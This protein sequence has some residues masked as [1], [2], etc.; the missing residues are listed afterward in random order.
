MS[1]VT[2]VGHGARAPTERYF[3]MSEVTT[4]GHKDMETQSTH[5][6]LF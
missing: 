4:V 2:T 5:R 6:A 3:C 1:E